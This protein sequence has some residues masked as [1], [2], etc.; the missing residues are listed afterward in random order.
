[1]RASSAAANAR[2]GAVSRMAGRHHRFSSH[3][4]IV[5]VNRPGT[6]APVAQRIQVS[7]T[8]AYWRAKS[9]IKGLAAMPVRNMAEATYVV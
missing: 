2:A 5:S 6:M 9:A 7:S 8:W 1:M 4:T 3:G